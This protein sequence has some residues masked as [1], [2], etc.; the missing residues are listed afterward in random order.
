LLPAK[1]HQFKKLCSAAVSFF[2]NGS[3]TVPCIS[4]RADEICRLVARNLEIAIQ[5]CN[6]AL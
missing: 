6:L 2:L 1:P 5:L 4:C 3:Q